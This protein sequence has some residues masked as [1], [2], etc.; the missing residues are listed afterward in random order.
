MNLQGTASCFLDANENPFGEHNRYPDPYQNDL[1]TIVADRNRIEEDRIFV[2]NG[3]DE[4]IDLVV[5]YI[6]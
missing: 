1:K 6:L 3:S 2:G 4:A 5:P